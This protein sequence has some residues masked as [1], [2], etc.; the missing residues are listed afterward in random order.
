MLERG[1]SNLMFIIHLENMEY[2][3]SNQQDVAPDLLQ[4]ANGTFQHSRLPEINM[5]SAQKNPT[6][7]STNTNKNST[8][9]GL[10]N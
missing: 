3:P 5:I 1:G 10:L 4:R 6:K 9:A 2:H 8:R 7:T